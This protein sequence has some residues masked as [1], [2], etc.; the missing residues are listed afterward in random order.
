MSLRIQLAFEDH[1]HDQYLVR[2]V[3]E[4]LLKDAGLA[5]SQV[6]AITD[7]RIRGVEDL[8]ANACMILARYGPISD[9]VIFAI[10]ADRQDGCEGRRDRKALFEATLAACES[11]SENYVVVVAHQELEVWALWGS[12]AE[13]GAPWKTVRAEQHP[14]EVYLDKLL[15]QADLRAPGKGRGR[16][17]EK[18]LASG[19]TSLKQGCPELAVF[20]TEL[21]KILGRA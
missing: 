17:I 8:R 7:P 10:D 12:R 21:L 5:R 13:L 19:W 6:R 20:E 3:V 1:T 4:A 9:V 16:L 18:S 15:T 11:D 14:K 2:P